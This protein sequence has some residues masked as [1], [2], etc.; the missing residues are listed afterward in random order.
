MSATVSYVRPVRP[1]PEPVAVL[2]STFMNATIAIAQAVGV[3]TEMGLRIINVQASW[4]SLPTVHL[5]ECDALR[6]RV[7]REEAVYF[8]FSTDPATG[9]QF[10]HGQFQIS[11]VRCIWVEQVSQ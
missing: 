4:G 6:E 10:R 9:R 3:L 8:S 2:N 5:A 11:G 1:A 7:E